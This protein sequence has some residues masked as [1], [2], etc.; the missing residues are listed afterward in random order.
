[1]TT[2]LKKYLK[3]FI[4]FLIPFITTN[5]LPYRHEDTACV[6]SQDKLIHSIYVIT[7]Y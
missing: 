2:K 1:M 7:V 5:H 6:T 4:A 3:G